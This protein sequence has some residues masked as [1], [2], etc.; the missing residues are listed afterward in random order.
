[1]NRRDLSLCL[2]GALAGVAGPAMASTDAE[3]T[4]QDDLEARC[5]REVDEL[6]RFF[7]DW[8]LARLPATDDAFQRFASVMDDNFLIISPSGRMMRRGSLVDH[9]RSAHG[10]WKATGN[11]K[12]WIEKFQL[13]R[14]LG[15]AALVTYEEWQ[16]RGEA[17]RGR[18]SSALLG[19]RPET[20]NGVA[21][22]H[23]HEVWLPE[24]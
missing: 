13:Q 14:T 17:P 18:L 6:H 12:I 24:G 15:D 3:P 19:P 9:L 5:R 1:M 22:L 23:L 2:F 4:E 21:W 16:Q 11:A 7:E 10:A 20:P 8:F